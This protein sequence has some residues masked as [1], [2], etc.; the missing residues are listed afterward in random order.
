MWKDV[1]D[2]FF[3]YFSAC[4]IN[5]EF[6]KS[7]MLDFKEVINIDWTGSINVESPE[8]SFW[9]NFVK[10]FLETEGLVANLWKT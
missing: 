3:Y 7:I 9:S 8:K 10:N 4:G 6:Q 5:V 1:S 2:I